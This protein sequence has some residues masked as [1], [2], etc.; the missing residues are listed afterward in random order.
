MIVSAQRS[1]P[2]APSVAKALFRDGS[3]V[4]L[5]V[6]FLLCSLCGAWGLLRSP[7]A[8]CTQEDLGRGPL[9]PSWNTSPCALHC[10]WLG[11]TPASGSPATASSPGN[12]V[13]GSVLLSGSPR[14]SLWLPGSANFL[15]DK[16]ARSSFRQVCSVSMRSSG[17]HSTL[18]HGG[19]FSV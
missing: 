7:M 3:R 9:N 6:S 12:F 5:C 4:S 13:P 2:S 16:R 10:C 15:Q 19:N 17:T 14:A 1:F 11:Q 8:A 18:H